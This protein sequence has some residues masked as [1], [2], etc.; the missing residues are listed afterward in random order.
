MY[1]RLLNDFKQLLELISLGRKL[2]RMVIGSLDERQAYFSIKRREAPI[3]T[4]IIFRITKHIVQITGQSRTLN[5]EII[6]PCYSSSR[7]LYC[8]QVMV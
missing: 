4:I 6:A 1:M 5:N 7:N 3:E 2:I 8:N